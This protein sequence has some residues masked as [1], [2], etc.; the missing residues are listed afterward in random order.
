MA[1]QYR[2]RTEG[3][4]ERPSVYV[5]PEQDGESNFSLIIRNYLQKRAQT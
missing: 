5:V 1:D 2:T 4:D 3:E